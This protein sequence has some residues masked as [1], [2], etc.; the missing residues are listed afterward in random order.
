MFGNS[1][2]YFEITSGSKKSQGKYKN[3]D[4]HDNKNTMQKNLS[5]TGNSVLRGNFIAINACL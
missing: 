4:L 1:G 3:S 5:D 2:T